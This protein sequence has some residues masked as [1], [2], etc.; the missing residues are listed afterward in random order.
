M[1]DRKA[2]KY[3]FSRAGIPKCPS[4]IRG[5]DEITGGGLPRGRPT[6]VA[7]SAGCGKTLF[8][9][10]FLVRGA[11]EH[12]EP[13]VFMAFEESARDL[14]QN[15]AS[16]GFDL[17]DLAARKKLLVDF[18]S[19]ERTEIQETGEYDLGGLFIRLGHA[20]DSIGA[21]RVV[22]DTIESLFAGLSNEAILRSELRRLFRWLKKKG[23]TAVITAERGENT[24]S[25][26]GLEEYVADCVIML[27]HRVT[28][29]VSTRRARVVKYRGS[30]HETNEFPFL[31]G[32]DG[33]FLL[34]VTSMGLDYEVTTARIST[35]IPRLD[36]MLGGKGYFRGSS[37]LVTG[38]PGTGKTSI[39]STFADAACRRGERCIYIAFEEGREQIF[40]NMR[41][42]G[43]DLAAW[44]AKGL[45]HVH[46]GRPTV[47]GLE[48]H[49]LTI[50]RLGDEF[51]PKVVVIDPISNLAE[52]GNQVDVK[53]MLSRLI[54]HFKSNGVT[55]FFTSLVAKGSYEESSGVGISSLMDTWLQL[56]DIEKSGEHNRGLFILKSRGMAHSNQIREFLLSDRGIDLLDVPVS[57][58][59]LL[60]GSAR[61]AMERQRME[62][63][64]QGRVEL[65]LKKRLFEL[66]RRE[67]AAKVASIETGF[68]AEAED[69]KEY[70]RTETNRQEAARKTRS[71]LGRARK[72]D[73]VRAGGNPKRPAIQRGRG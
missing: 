54:D 42:I 27:D 20:I 11:L 35:G 8:A 66:K 13:G 15:V 16:L 61:V 3:R 7:G 21:K 53:A 32:D 17:A 34:P 50:H 49:I 63:E 73:P 56:E 19:I 29:Q 67:K 51:R 39:A 47:A 12:G 46:A 48:T 26:H 69:F 62:E 59:E 14:A 28:E 24:I 44:A 18:V 4:G 45:L 25:R 38:T 60:M 30:R 5:L 40:R 23:V 64:R 68:E 57:S 55:T 72:A 70:L 6:L 52:V 41:S 31:I 33:I 9:M 65:D 1:A 36:T 10:E 71:A 2:G 37:I 22:L 58:G 43:I